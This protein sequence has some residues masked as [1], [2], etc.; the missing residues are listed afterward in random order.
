MPS[1][2]AATSA[3]AAFSNP[4]GTVSISSPKELTCAT[5]ASE[6]ESIVR[7]AILTN[8]LGASD[9]SRTPPPAATMIAETVNLLLAAPNCRAQKNSLSLFRHA[10]EIRTPNLHLQQ[11]RPAPQNERPGES[12]GLVH[13]GWIAAA[14]SRRS[15]SAL[16]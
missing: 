16:P 7:P 2:A 1:P 3:R 9:P 12:P 10:S 4:S 11:I 14:S 5:A 6:Y 8:A 13:A 15:F